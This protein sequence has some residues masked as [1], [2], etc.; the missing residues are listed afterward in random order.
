MKYSICKIDNIDIWACP[1]PGLHKKYSKYII[2]LYLLHITIIGHQ[3]LSY[4]WFGL[5]RF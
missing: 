3:S 2:Y 1:F 4:H 5:V